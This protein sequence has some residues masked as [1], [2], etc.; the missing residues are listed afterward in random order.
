MEGGIMNATCQRQRV[1]EEE[2]RKERERAVCCIG[3][4]WPRG[5]REYQI[6]KVG[7]G[8]IQRQRERERERERESPFGTA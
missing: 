4:A 2:R 7:R 5:A 8:K 3:F 1:R 6:A